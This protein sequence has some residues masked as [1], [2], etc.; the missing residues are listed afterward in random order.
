MFN[1]LKQFKDMRDQAKQFQDTLA[2]E[3]ITAKAAGG[4]VS[5]TLDGNLTMTNILID[6]SLL[7]PDKKNKLEEAIR[8]AH[9]DAI[10]KIQQIMALK[11]KEMG[12]LPNIPGLN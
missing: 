7:S 4:A 10:K 12:G 2:K 1:K 8:E 9:G 11:M 6:E 3:S 5:M